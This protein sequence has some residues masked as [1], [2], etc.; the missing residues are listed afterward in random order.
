MHD[1]VTI[2]GIVGTPPRHIVTA[3]GLPITS[4]RLASTHRWF[5][6][7]TSKWV[8]G[9]TNWYD[10]STF[11]HLAVNVASSVEKGD[12]VILVGKLKVR[13]WE[14]ATRTG[15]SVEVE[16]D[17]LGHDL[18]WGSTRYTRTPAGARAHAA[19]LPAGESAADEPFDP[20]GGA[21]DLAEPDPEGVLVPAS[22]EVE[23]PF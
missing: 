10:V 16:A 23:T 19:G 13:T 17:A 1:I 14:N 22:G 21:A 11:R 2:T 20:D 4:F 7:A 15:T 3:E 6:R 12:P 8:N 9:E 18:H 5:D